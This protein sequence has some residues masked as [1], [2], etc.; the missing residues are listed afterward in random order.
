MASS[1]RSDWFPTVDDSLTG[2]V[3]RN[4]F[5]HDK[6]PFWKVCALWLYICWT[7]TYHMIH[8]VV[9]FIGTRILWC[10]YLI[11]IMFVTLA[12][13]RTVKKKGKFKAVSQ[14][15]S[16]TA[17]QRSFKITTKG[18]HWG[19]GLFRMSSCLCIHTSLLSTC[20]WSSLLTLLK[21]SRGAS[22][23]QSLSPVVNSQ[24]MS[25]NQMI[26][27]T[28]FYSQSILIINTG[29]RLL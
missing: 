18:C 10:Y 16:Q 6:R 12:F 7:L 5:S 23:M 9:V 21:D 8:A 20:I 11:N 15:S 2:S 24:V 13:C 25:S 19:Q 28:V 1:H 4:A 29:K 26:D 27:D 3:E 14:K 17:G 22:G